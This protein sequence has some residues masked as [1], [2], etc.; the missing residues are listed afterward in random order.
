MKM[1]LKPVHYLREN[2]N[3]CKAFS[4]NALKTV[5]GDTDLLFYQLTSRSGEAL[6]L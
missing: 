6:I 1:P 4:L 3:K 5:L 2:K